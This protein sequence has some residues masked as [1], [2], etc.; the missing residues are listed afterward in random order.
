MFRPDCGWIE[1]IHSCA[2][3][4]GK[5]RELL[6]RLDHLGWAQKSYILFKPHKDNRNEHNIAKSHNGN[7]LSATSVS[8]P[9]EILDITIRKQPDAVAIDE[10]QFFDTKIIDIVSQLRDQGY[11]VIIAGLSSTSEGR[12]FNSMPYLLSISDNITPIYGVC[13]KCGGIA[14]KTIAL[15]PK[16][17]DVEV[18]GKEKYE[19]RCNK[20]WQEDYNNTDETVANS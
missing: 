6:R 13:A 1:T 20:C 2:M 18:G 7:T 9:Q 11:W 16:S 14:T 3:F 5:T 10:A 19:P 8:S 12:P 4:A 15:F 17:T